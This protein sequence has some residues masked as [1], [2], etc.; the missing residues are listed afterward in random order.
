MIAVENRLKKYPLERKPVG[1]TVRETGLARN[2]VC[3]CISRLR[4]Q[5]KGR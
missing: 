5:S 1:Q 2:N 4:L 3:I